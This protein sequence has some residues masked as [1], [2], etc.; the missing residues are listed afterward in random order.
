MK[1]PGA[2]LKFGAP[3]GEPAPPAKAKRPGA[4]IVR[5]RPREESKAGVAAAG[6]GA[7]KAEKVAKPAAPEP[8]AAGGLGLGNY[9]S[10]ESQ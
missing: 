10:D 2:Q 3:A 8:P 5:K 6:A 7:E 9:D 1:A 4:L